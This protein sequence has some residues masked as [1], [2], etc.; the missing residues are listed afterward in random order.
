MNKKL[1][2]LVAVASMIVACKKKTYDFTY[3]PTSPRAGQKVSFQNISDSGESWTWN[4]DDNGISS[5]KSPYHI[6]SE[7]GTYTVTLMVDSSKH[8]VVRHKITIVDSIPTFVASADTFLQY[9]LNTFK[10]ELWNPNGSNVT[11]AWEFPENFFITKGRID[12]AVVTGY[13][14][15]FNIEVKVGLT[16]NLDNTPTYI[17]RSY[18]VK[19]NPAQALLIENADGCYRQRIYDTIMENYIPYPEGATLLATAN[20]SNLTYNGQNFKVGAMTILTEYSITAIQID[21]TRGKI[22]FLANGL[23]VANIN[24][25][26]PACITSNAAGTL[27]I[28]SEHKY[29]YFSASDGTYRVPLVDNPKNLITTELTKKIARVNTLTN[30]KRL[31][32]DTNKH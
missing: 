17:S 18:Y 28:D 8:K 4:F 5:M 19:D 15:R 6:F 14:T 26:Y 20:D 1:L 23:Y 32:V 31:I 22:Y 7:A 30:I 29:L 21:R 13:F 2:I 16:V 24:G 10:A 9:S 12:T 25:E 11:Y 3:S 27:A